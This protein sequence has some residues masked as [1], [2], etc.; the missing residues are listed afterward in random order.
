MLPVHSLHSFDA[1]EMFRQHLAPQAMSIR[2]RPCM[3]RLPVLGEARL[4]EGRPRKCASVA[5]CVLYCSRRAA[6][7]IEPKRA[8]AALLKFLSECSDR[9]TRD[10]TNLSFPS[11]M[12]L[13]RVECYSLPHTAETNRARRRNRALLCTAGEMRRWTMDGLARRRRIAERHLLLTQHGRS[14]SAL[15]LLPLTYRGFSARRK[16]RQLACGCTHR[17]LKTFAS[18]RC[19]GRLEVPPSR[20]H[21]PCFSSSE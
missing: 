8:P 14:C 3:R 13:D 11:H 9:R 17:E 7:I 21:P 12:R 18:S 2:A 16:S 4:F 15:L 10:R 5:V 19:A 6:A 1:L 20:R